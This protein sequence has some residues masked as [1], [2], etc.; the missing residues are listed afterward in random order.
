MKL[1]STTP[2]CGNR[3][4]KYKECTLETGTKPVSN[5][6]FFFDVIQSL[7]ILMSDRGVFIPVTAL[8]D[9]KTSNDTQNSD[10]L[11]KMFHDF[12]L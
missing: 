8:D 3:A 7:R 4:S 11:P 1:S 10:E 9:C 2:K 5:A 6:A 12:L